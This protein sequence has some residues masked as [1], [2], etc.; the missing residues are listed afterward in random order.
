MR[1]RAQRTKQQKPGGHRFL[2]GRLIYKGLFCSLGWIS[3]FEKIRRIG[4]VLRVINYNLHLIVKT[5]RYSGAS[6]HPELQANVFLSLSTSR[7]LSTL[8]HTGVTC[9][10]FGLAQLLL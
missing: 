10:I 3:A 2:R 9:G 8:P 5:K 4:F 1:E 6:E 7:L